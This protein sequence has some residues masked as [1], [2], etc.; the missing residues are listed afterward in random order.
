MKLSDTH[1]HLNL[2]DFSGDLPAVLQRA[3]QAGVDFILI[4]G[5]DLETSR[6]AVELA[7]K[8]K[9]VFAAVG[10]HPNEAEKW[11]ETS[12]HNLRRLASH[13]K[14]RAVGEIGLDYYR[15]DVEKDLQKMVLYTQLNLAAELDLPVILHNRQASDDLYPLLLDRCKDLENSPQKHIRLP[16]VLHAF[17]Q[18]HPL[19]K[20][21]I[22]AG[23][24]FGLGGPVTFKNNKFLPQLVT[25]IPIN[26]VLLETDAPYL[27]PHPYRGHR[28][29][30][31]NIQYIAAKIAS[32][33][34]LDIHE[35]AEITYNNAARLFS[36][37]EER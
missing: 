17:S 1:C 22:E 15:N 33:W 8:H 11:N 12:I 19:L 32:L 24:Y 27:S 29:E 9:N 30:P 10:F 18:A 4:P 37:R 36:R 3:E 25:S 20:Q 5:I 6:L 14:V 28:N 21:I 31:A 35:V 34:A 26:R 16:G 2:D 7:E 23:F 13:P